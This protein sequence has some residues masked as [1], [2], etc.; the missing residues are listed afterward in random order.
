MNFEED[1]KEILYSVTQCMLHVP[2]LDSDQKQDYSSRVQY[3]KQTLSL[4]V[5]DM[6]QEC[7]PRPMSIKPV[8][9]YERP[10]VTVQ[11]HSF[12]GE[13]M[14]CFS[15]MNIYLQRSKKLLDNE[16]FE[17][18]KG[19]FRIIIDDFDICR[20]LGND[21]AKIIA[22]LDAICIN[23][24]RCFEELL[25]DLLKYFKIDIDSKAIMDRILFLKSQIEGQ[26]L[27]CFFDL[28]NFCAQ[29]AHVTDKL[30]PKDPSC[31]KKRCLS[32]E[33]VF[34]SFYLVVEVIK[35]I[36]SKANWKPKSNKKYDAVSG[37]K[38]KTVMCRNWEKYNMCPHG[39]VCLFAHGEEQLAV[40][41]LSTYYGDNL[42]QARRTNNMIEKNVELGHVNFEE[43]EN[44]III[45]DDPKSELTPDNAQHY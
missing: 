16:K 45:H 40:S 35:D 37:V 8:L 11:E 29:F 41:M 30:N 4:I 32:A 15:V 10:F 26:K 2:D 33:K 14:E 21:N 31:F 18:L 27:N 25:T 12:G 44:S 1:L 23:F 36:Y 6:K 13:R 17:N 24:R 28:N 19:Y 20:K 38:Y 39:N 34:N 7:I 9:E 22:K 5:N 43:I 42:K 3:I